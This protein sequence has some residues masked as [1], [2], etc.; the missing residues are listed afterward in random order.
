MA[1]FTIWNTLTI[2][3]NIGTIVTGN[4]LVS[5]AHKIL[6]AFLSTFEVVCQYAVL[7]WAGGVEQ[8]HRYPH[9]AE[10]PASLLR[11]SGAGNNQPI[12]F[13]QIIYV[14]PEVLVDIPSLLKIEK[15][16]VIVRLHKLLLQCIDQRRSEERRRIGECKADDLFG[17]PGNL[18]WS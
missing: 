11:K 9:L 5:A 2:A 1:L 14:F 7:S 17:L 12:H 4:T 15:H 6:G 8:N 13:L 10:K 3:I 16:Q 18:L